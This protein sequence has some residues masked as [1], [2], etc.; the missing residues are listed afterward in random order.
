METAPVGTI[1]A[2]YQGVNTLVDSLGE[3][4]LIPQD[5]L[6]MVR[7]MLAMF[8][9]PVAGEPDRM[10]T[11]LEFREGGAVFANGQQIK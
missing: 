7:M 10:T 2:E 5:Q 11:E 1:H 6:G 3:M 9:K 8:A 4:G